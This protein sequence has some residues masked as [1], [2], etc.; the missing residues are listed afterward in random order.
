MW[1]DPDGVEA[2]LA[3]GGALGLLGAVVFVVA[4]V[5]VTVRFMRRAGEL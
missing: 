2:F 4:V 3:S 5:G 1:A